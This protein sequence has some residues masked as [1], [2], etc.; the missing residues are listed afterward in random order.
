M[1]H[2]FL[3]LYTVIDLLKKKTFKAFSVFFLIVMCVT[4]AHAFTVMCVTSAHALWPEL[5]GQTF[6]LPNTGCH[7]MKD[8]YNQPIG[9]GKG[10]VRDS[11]TPQPTHPISSSEEPLIRMS[12][13]YFFGKRQSLFLPKQSQRSRSVL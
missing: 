4:P 9:F 1:A 2:E 10:N 5:S 11:W 6:L 12:V 3:L 13:L 7:S 8:G